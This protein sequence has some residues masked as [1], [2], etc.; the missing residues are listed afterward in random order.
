MENGDKITIDVQKG[1]LSHHLSDHEVKER[2][3]KWEPLEKM[4]LKGVLKKYK[5]TV[6]SAST[7]AVTT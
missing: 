3:R 7:G 4:K 2:K 6:S 5:E 1:T